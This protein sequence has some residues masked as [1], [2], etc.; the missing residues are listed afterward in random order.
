MARQVG[1]EVMEHVYRGHVARRSGEIYLVPRPHFFMVPGSRAD[2]RKLW[3]DEPV[4]LSSHPNPWDY[5]TRVPIIMHGKKWAGAGVTNYDVVDIADVPATYA[6]LLGIETEQELDGEPLPGFDTSGPDPK[7][8]F[9]VVI[10]G[11]GWNALQQHSE[12]HP[13]IDSLREQ[14]TTYMNA[15]I[16]SAPSITGALHA[17]FGTGVYPNKHGL[18]GNQMRGPD[19]EN[20]DTW[21]DAADP[22]YLRVPA[23]ADLW[24]EQ[25]GN[26][27]VV[28]TVSYEGWHLGMI[29]HGAQR[30][31]G[32]QDIAALWEQEPGEW[33]INEDYYRLPRGLESTDTA[34]LESYEEEL[35]PRDGLTDGTWFGHDL[36]YLRAPTVRPGH[37]AFVRFTGDAVVDM[38]R[39]EGIGTDDVTD[40]V[41]IEMKMP[42]FAGHAWN[43]IN[44]EQG[45]VLRETD[46]QLARFKEELDRLVGAGEYVYAVSAD[47]GQQPLPDLLGGWRINQK[48]LEDDITD[49]FGDVLEKSTPVDLYVDGE[50][51][52]N[53]GVS[54]DD[55]ARFLG[56]YTIGDN[57]PDDAPG[58]DRVPEEWLD[59][60]IFA[61]AFSTD[62]LLALEPDAIE[63]LGD[64]DHEEGRL[65]ISPD[66]GG[67]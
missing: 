53:E 5:L 56:A 24:D 7:V 9:T 29:G 18:P 31:G 32:D 4:L 15:T 12:A 39:D 60:P 66:G 16:A 8:V 41:W 57:I 14:G 40:F 59:D 33:W 28:A 48:E 2:L 52:E 65:T 1:S 6:E 21:R 51:M 36:D 49:A 27:P 38:L 17:T 67:G 45:D 26:R 37:P 23:V 62:Y 64:G 55:I 47:H 42:D 50:G 61:G 54:L 3:T 35:D 10:D 63:A 13:F 22:R 34:R 44:R 19:G 43:M 20:T 30:D 46:R 11:G 58:A 25:Q